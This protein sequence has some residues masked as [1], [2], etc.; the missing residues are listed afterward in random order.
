MNQSKKSELRLEMEQRDK[1]DQ[2]I[3]LVIV[4]FVISVTFCFIFA[5][6]VGQLVYTGMLYELP[7]LTRPQA[8]KILIPPLAAAMVFG[9][10]VQYA[11]LVIYSKFS[12]VINSRLKTPVQ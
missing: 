10:V 4:T 6:T 9:T 8:H 3:V 1:E 7:T 2:F 12:K 5:Y 11:T